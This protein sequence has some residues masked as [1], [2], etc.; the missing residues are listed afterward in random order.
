MTS[1]SNPEMVC[2]FTAAKVN[3]DL[4]MSASNPDV[5]SSVTPMYEA[6]PLLLDPTN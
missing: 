3:C 1:Q 5:M 4:V 6:V 2:P